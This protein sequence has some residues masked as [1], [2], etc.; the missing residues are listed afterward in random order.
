MPARPKKVKGAR[1]EGGLN[2]SD[3]GDLFFCGRDPLRWVPARSG[4]TGGDLSAD[5]GTG[6]RARRQQPERSRCREQVAR[7]RRCVWSQQFPWPRCTGGRG[8][9]GVVLVLSGCFAIRV[10]VLCVQVCVCPVSVSCR[11][12]VAWAKTRQKIPKHV[13]L[14][15]TYMYCTGDW[16]WTLR[17]GKKKRV[18]MEGGPVDEERAPAA[19][20]RFPQR[21]CSVRGAP[22][23]L[24]QTESRVDC[25]SQRGPWRGHGQRGPSLLGKIGLPSHCGSPPHRVNE[26]SDI[27]RQG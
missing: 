1:G 21:A 12:S 13:P 25:Q 7:N 5:R 8:P 19:G 10:S 17:Q 9:D 2:Q 24:G 3:P 6:V 26:V 11:R 20:G 18:L 22:P 16:Y 14:C 4:A 23:A 27:Y 15:S